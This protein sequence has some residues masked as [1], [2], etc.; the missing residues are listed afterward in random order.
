MSTCRVW[1]L[2]LWTGVWTPVRVSTVGLVCPQTRWVTS[3]T[4]RP[5]H[6]LPPRAPSASARRRD[7]RGST[8]RRVSC[9]ITVLNLPGDWALPGPSL[10]TIMPNNY[11]ASSIILFAPS[12]NCTIY[13][14]VYTLA[15]RVVKT[16]LFIKLICWTGGGRG[17]WV[18]WNI[19]GPSA[20]HIMRSTPL[21]RQLTEFPG[22]NFIR[23]FSG[24]F[25]SLSWQQQ[26]GYRVNY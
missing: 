5:T 19:V 3:P 15:Q 9:R 23:N 10:P 21:S 7:T 16:R 13:M 26:S 2:A 14:Y 8:A 11:L 25:S 24:K 6:R 4:P 12:C 1:G 22:Y 18:V 20:G 17:G